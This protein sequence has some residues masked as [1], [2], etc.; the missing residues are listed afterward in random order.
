[1]YFDWRRQEIAANHFGLTRTRESH[2]PIYFSEHTSAQV[3]MAFR[4]HTRPKTR[5]RVNTQNTH[6]HTH[7]YNDSVF[8]HRVYFCIHALN[9]KRSIQADTQKVS[10][11]SAQTMV[12]N[13]RNFIH[14]EKGREGAGGRLVGGRLR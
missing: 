1:M 10:L 11:L 7:K 14:T 2:F 12:A 3:L 4:A 5:I 6:T 13:Q 9:N 8:C